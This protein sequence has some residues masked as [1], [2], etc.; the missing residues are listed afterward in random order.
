MRVSLQLHTEG[1]VAPI[2]MA[3]LPDDT[4]RA[5]V[6]DQPGLIH[7]REANGTLRAEPLLDVRPRLVRLNSGY[8]ERGLLGM[9]LHP[10]FASNGRMFVYYSAKRRSQ[11]PHDFDHTGRLAELRVNPQRLPPTDIQHE[12]VILEVDQPQAN[13][14]GGAV[15][16]GPDGMLY[17]ALGDG[18]AANDRGKGHAPGGNGQSLDTLLGKIVRID[19]DGAAPYAIPPDNPFMN[20]EGAD[21]IFAYGLRNPW[22]FSFR[23]DGALLVGDVGQHL[24]EEVSVVR[25]GGNLGWNLMEGAHCFNPDTPGTSPKDCARTG[26]HGEPLVLPVIELENSSTFP[27][28][29]GNTVIGG[30]LYRGRAIPSLK[31]RYVFGMW[32]RDFGDAS[33]ALLVAEARERGMWPFQPLPLVEGDGANIGRFV[34]SLAEDAEGELYVLTAGRGGPTGKTGKVFKLVPAP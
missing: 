33:G 7:V 9:A 21:E 28:G 18:G 2:Q 10:G 26:A 27:D 5:L 29:I 30:Y 8:D 15:A 12:R 3:F 16:F 32:S 25:K 34:L 4:G 13:H 14:N 17:L 1:L 20:R 24:W 23:D 19:V 6:A 11:A 22:R 31:G